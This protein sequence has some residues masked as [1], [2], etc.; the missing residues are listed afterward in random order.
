MYR[1]VHTVSV[2]RIRDILVRIRIRIL[3]SVPLTNV[4]GFRILLFS[5]VTCKTP[6][7]NIFFF[8]KFYSYSF[9]KVW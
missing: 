5:S 6:K 1:T 2:F 7:K 3:G 4:S 8:S 9:L